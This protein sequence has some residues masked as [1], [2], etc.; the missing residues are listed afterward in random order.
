MATNQTITPEQKKKLQ[1]Q[2]EA[3]NGKIVRKIV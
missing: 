3:M 1:E 2:K